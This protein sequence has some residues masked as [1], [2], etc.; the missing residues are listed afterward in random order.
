MKLFRLSFI[1][2]LVLAVQTHAQTLV[3]EGRDHETILMTDCDKI[4]MFPYFN[5]FESEICGRN[6]SCWTI[7]SSG[8]HWIDNDAPYV[9]S[10]NHA[11]WLGTSLGSLC[12]VALPEVDTT[13]VSL[14][15]LRLKFMARWH[16]M[17]D[18]NGARIIV[19]VMEE[20]EDVSTFQAV[21]TLSVINE[22]QPFVVSFEN[23]GGQGTYPVIIPCSLT[24]SSY[25]MTYL[26]DVLLER[27][28]DCRPPQEIYIIDSSTTSLTIDWNDSED[29]ESYEVSYVSNLSEEPIIVAS[30]VHP[31]VLNDL[32]PSE[33]YQV[34]VRFLCGVGDTSEWSIPLLASTN[35]DMIPLSSSYYQDFEIY[36]VTNVGYS[37]ILPPC[38]SSY[39]TDLRVPHIVTSRP[40]G[41]SLYGIY[42]H[43]RNSLTFQSG[44]AS[45][46]G[47]INI[48]ALPKF[49]EPINTIEMSFWLC[50]EDDNHGVL[51]VG[52]ITDDD[53]DPE[54]FVAV[55]SIPASMA[56]ARMGNGEMPAGV[57]I[58]R[59]VS[60][61][62]VPE[63]ASK[64]AFLWF[65][66]VSYYAAC[67]DDIMVST[68]CTC[69]LYDTL[70]VEASVT[71]A[72]VFWEEEG[73]YS[74]S[75]KSS[76]S[77]E[78]SVSRNVAVGTSVVLTDLVPNTEYL[79]RIRKYCS[80]TD[81]SYYKYVT[82]TTDS[83]I[84]EVPAGL[85]VV[86][87]H[88]SG[89]DLD[90][91]ADSGYVSEWVIHLFGGD[92]DYYDTLDVTSIEIGNLD[93]MTTYCI[94]LKRSCGYGYYGPW[95]DTIS[96]TTLGSLSIPNIDDMPYKFHIYPNPATQV[97]TISLSGFAGKVNVQVVDLNGR[98]AASE[99]MECD[100]NC[101]K[102]MNVDNLAQGTYF[103]RVYGDTVNMVRK[104]VVR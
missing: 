23:Y 78:W 16:D 94:S 25:P 65:C 9:Y 33:T 100:G 102:T 26:D 70:S 5:D 90:W 18:C 55:D 61:S 77:E 34:R 30:Y 1:L 56:T 103:V 40:S 84:C 82:F 36:N 41:R 59:T 89:V 51:Y 44:I 97:T 71:S 63:S 96:F 20:V 66:N 37:G 7:V 87:C 19:G 67:V 43:E 91:S 104:L 13:V 28:P 50:T 21:D 85:S 75:Y 45:D 95:S 22:Y 76:Q 99:Y 52:Y 24:S 11:L 10:G 74:L 93:T 92:V 68:T 80:T 58:N 57:G 73:V 27:I 69:P 48:V 39:S 3:N 60:F 46:A 4:S 47:P 79:C 6:P 83:M 12:R 15:E 86:Q 42:T 64:I 98:V 49:A 81:S 35:C 62:N 101:V 17:N 31:V 8:S 29:C 72:E 2:G 53:P 14:N 88:D 54:N 38:W 32:V